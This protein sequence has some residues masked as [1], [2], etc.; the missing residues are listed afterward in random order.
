MNRIDTDFFLENS[1]VFDELGTR[2]RHIIKRMVCAA[3]KST[4]KAIPLKIVHD[5]IYFVYHGEME[6]HYEYKTST[7]RVTRRVQ[8]GEVWYGGEPIENAHDIK[9]IFIEYADKAE[10]GILRLS[11]LYC[12]IAYRKL[13]EKIKKNLCI[14]ESL[15][16]ELYEAHFFPMTLLNEKILEEKVMST[17]YIVVALLCTICGYIFFIA[18]A[19]AITQYFHSSTPATGLVILTGI[20]IAI[21]FIRFGPFS[22]YSMGL[23]WTNSRRAMQSALLSI[24]PFLLIGTGIKYLLIQYAPQFH[25]VPLFE[26][27]KL[28][29]EMGLYNYIFDIGIYLMFIA[30]TEEFICRGLVQGSLQSL[31]Y[32]ERDIW[33]PII[34]AN[35]FFAVMHIMIS[36]T[37]TIVVFLPGLCWGYLFARDND[38]VAVSVAHG[39]LG[40]IMF[41]GIGYT[42]IFGGA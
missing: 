9:N 38:L 10:I 41:Y 8:E 33:S 17:Q 34:I 2:E 12:L 36:F 31:F 29:R 26:Y 28:I 23:T 25:H 16:K 6:I 20:S 4:S 22:L 1:V 24:I 37:A 11:D 3:P 27:D 35:L 40:S 19:K 15:H 14:E 39:L 21:F 7:K 13:Y 32:S 42:S 5:S 18:A 30:P